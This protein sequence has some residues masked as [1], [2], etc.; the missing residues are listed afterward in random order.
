[1]L[2][3]CKLEIHNLFYEILPQCSFIRELQFVG[4]DKVSFLITIATNTNI[5]LSN[6]FNSLMQHIDT[7]KYP[8]SHSIY[9]VVN[10]ARV[11]FYNDEMA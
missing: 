2:D 9:S 6:V 5:A 3:F 10:K 11:G 4:G 7:S 8:P 1:M